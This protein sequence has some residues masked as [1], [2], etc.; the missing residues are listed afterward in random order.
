[1]K[2]D[3]ILRLKNVIRQTPEF[4]VV[5]GKFNHNSINWGLAA[6]SA[7]Y[8]HTGDGNID[9]RDIDIWIDFKDRERVGEI[10]TVDW[11]LKSSERHTAENIEIGCIDVFTNC[12]KYKNGEEIL[13]Y[14]WTNSVEEHL[15]KAIV[16]GIEYKIISPEDVALLKIANP[17]HEKEREQ[18]ENLLVNYDNKYLELRKR[19]CRFTPQKE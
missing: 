18:A 10:M 16:D 5:A 3:K 19:E 6:G 9:D 14:L 4:S 13:N 15:E 12:K 8:I 7:Y 2:K 11:V 1:M 17:R